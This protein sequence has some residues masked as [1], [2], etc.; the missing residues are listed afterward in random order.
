LGVDPNLKPFWKSSFGM[1]QLV[2]DDTKIF[3]FGL[4]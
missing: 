1:V 3:F 2:M 4:D